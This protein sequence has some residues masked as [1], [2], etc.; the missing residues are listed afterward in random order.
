MQFDS[1]DQAK[2]WKLLYPCI[3]MRKHLGP[4]VSTAT[5]HS[6]ISHG[7]GHLKL[8]SSILFRAVCC[9]AM[10]QSTWKFGSTDS[11]KMSKKRKMVFLVNWAN[12]QPWNTTLVQE[13]H[14]FVRFYEI[15]P[16]STGNTITEQYLFTG[17]MLFRYWFLQKL[18][19]P[20]SRPLAVPK[21]KQHSGFG[22][23]QQTKLC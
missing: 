3:F 18:R 6:N 8:W 7:P 20:G 5:S 11:V 13:L 21:T 14:Q 17:S 4:A 19:G 23:K 12:F 2:H 16:N 22:S 15:V 1:I 9:K 10:L